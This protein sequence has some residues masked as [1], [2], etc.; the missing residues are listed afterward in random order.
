VDYVDI[1]GDPQWLEFRFR[2]GDAIRQHDTN[3]M[4]TVG[5]IMNPTREGNSAT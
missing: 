5:W 1:F 2:N 4:Q 3:I